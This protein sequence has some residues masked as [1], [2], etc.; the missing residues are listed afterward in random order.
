MGYGNQ[1]LTLAVIMFGIKYILI[2]IPKLLKYNFDRKEKVKDCIKAQLIK[3]FVHEHA[4]IHVYD[5]TNYLTNKNKNLHYFVLFFN[6]INC[7]IFANIFLIYMLKITHYTQVNNNN[8][9]N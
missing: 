6:V 3:D 4:H 1:L 8:N 7:G 5:N 2:I 9:N